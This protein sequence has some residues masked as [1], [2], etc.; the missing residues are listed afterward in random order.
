[1]GGGC[2]GAES[3]MFAVLRPY[4]IIF[5]IILVLYLYS[6]RLHF[7]WDCLQSGGLMHHPWWV[8]RCFWHHYDLHLS[9]W[10][11]RC[12]SDSVSTLCTSR[13]R[14]GMRYSSW[15]SSCS[16]FRMYSVRKSSPYRPLC[17]TLIDRSEWRLVTLPTSRWSAGTWS[18]SFS[19]PTRYYR[20]LKIH[21]R[22][23]IYRPSH[24]LETNS[25]D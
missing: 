6:V 11:S 10:S 21:Q 4:C 18:P 16:C 2:G 9:R 22:R 13:R 8:W 7:L 14:L 23:R 15:R 20:C 5:L 24:S 19:S 17:W 1:M 25:I 12:A 3:L